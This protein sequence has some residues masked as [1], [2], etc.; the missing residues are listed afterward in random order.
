MKAQNFL[1]FLHS[2]SFIKN[3]TRRH[4]T[5]DYDGGLGAEARGLGGRWGY[6]IGIIPWRILRS[7]RLGLYSDFFEKF[8][9]TNYVLVV[10]AGDHYEAVGQRANAQSANFCD[11][12]SAIDQDVVIGCGNGRV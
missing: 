6:C 9:G 2:F 4:W 12:G 5:G 7:S 10:Q 8:L 11:A 1:K 3:F